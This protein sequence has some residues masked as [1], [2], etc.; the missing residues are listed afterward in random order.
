MFDLSKLK[1]NGDI[2]V[3]IIWSSNFKCNIWT[4]LG[5]LIWDTGY[6]TEIF[7]GDTCNIMFYLDLII[8][9]VCRQLEC[10][11]IYNCPQLTPNTNTHKKKEIRPTNPFFFRHVTRNEGCWFF[12]LNWHGFHYAFIFLLAFV[13]FADYAFFQW[14]TVA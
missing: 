8:W 2:C 9:E 12:G 4:V 1:L 10:V 7:P 13:Y 3:Y 5:R 11:Y 14:V 6:L